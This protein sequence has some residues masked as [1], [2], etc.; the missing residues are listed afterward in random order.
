MRKPLHSS[1]LIPPAT[2]GHLVRIRKRFGISLTELTMGCVLFISIVQFSRINLL[3]QQRR[4]FY[5]IFISSSSTFLGT[6]RFRFLLLSQQRSISYQ[7]LFIS[8]STL[9]RTFLFCF[10]TFVSA[11]SIMLPFFSSA[12]KYF[13]LYLP[14]P[15][16]R[17]FCGNE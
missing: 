14:A 11:T 2:C 16:F 15:F 5:Q 9:F 17:C 1:S 12:V 3:F 10:V 13:F 4:L 8:S 6:F 7:I